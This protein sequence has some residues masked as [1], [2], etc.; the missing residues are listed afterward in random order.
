MARRV[1]IRRS[2]NSFRNWFL[3]KHPIFSHP[4]NPIFSRPLPI[5]KSWMQFIVQEVQSPLFSSKIIRRGKL[6][7][8]ICRPIMISRINP[9]EFWRY[10]KIFPLSGEFPVPGFCCHLYWMLSSPFRI[11]RL[12]LFGWNVAS[13]VTV[14][15]IPHPPPLLTFSTTYLW[16]SSI[17]VLLH[18]KS[19]NQKIRILYCWLKIKMYIT[20]FL[21]D[22]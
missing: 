15:G 4:R 22:F 12:V 11:V 8:S 21:N 17:C 6:W 5:C 18:L 19:V 20:N 16:F 3:P 7:R 10:Y 2:R 1:W 9:P 13:T 14:S